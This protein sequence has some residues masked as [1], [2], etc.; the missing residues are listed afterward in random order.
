[1]YT[2]AQVVAGIRHIVTSERL[3]NIINHAT[4][5]VDRVGPL[6]EDDPDIAPELGTALAKLTEVVEAL[7]R[8]HEFS[9]A[10]TD[11]ALGDTLR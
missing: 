3:A 6:L 9:K 1:M 2:E 7:Q 11:V 5:M 10:R 4:W 8:A